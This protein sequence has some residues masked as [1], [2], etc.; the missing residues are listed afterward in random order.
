MTGGPK[1]VTLANARREARHQCRA[2]ERPDLHPPDRRRALARRRHPDL[3]DLRRLGD[4]P[5]RTDAASSTT[6][7]Y[8]EIVGEFERMGA[9]VLGPDEVDRSA[10]SPSAATT[11]QPGRAGPA[12]R[13][14]GAQASFGVRR[15][16]QG[17][18]RSAAVRPRPPRRTPTR[19]EKLMPVL[20]LVGPRA[21]NTPSSVRRGQR[22]RR[23]RPH[24]GRLLARRRRRAGVRE[25]GAHGAHPR[26]RRRRLSVHSAASTTT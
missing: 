24:L 1:V 10:T 17:P 22:E 5:R 16:R 13:R 26:E 8:D 3:E 25:R 12:G 19:A 9:K 21:S 23:A 6:E 20:G 14:L 18:H 15:R 7:I 4:L 2:G 11:C